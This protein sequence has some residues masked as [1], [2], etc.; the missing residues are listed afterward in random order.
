[1]FIQLKFNIL[2]PASTLR[3]IQA[4]RLF[5]CDKFY[6]KFRLNY[7]LHLIPIDSRLGQGNWD[8]V[9]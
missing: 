6:S 3:S 9:E 2:C 5:S 4:F 1:M 8:I 7:S